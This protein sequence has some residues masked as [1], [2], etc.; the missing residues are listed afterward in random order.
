MPDFF[1]LGGNS[2]A[3]LTAKEAGNFAPC[4]ENLSAVENLLHRY[5]INH[6]NSPSKT[7]LSFPWPMEVFLANNH[8]T[9]VTIREN[10]RRNLTPSCDGLIIKTKPAV[11]VC[12]PADC[13]AVAIR[14]EATGLVGMFHASRQT[15][16]TGVIDRF[17]KQW[18]IAGGRP[19]TTKLTILPSICGDC[20]ANGKDF[21]EKTVLPDLGKIVYEPKYFYRE[22][23]G[24][25]YLDLP[26]VIVNRL[27]QLGYYWI[28]RDDTCT[29]CDD[30]HWSA[31]RHDHDG[32]RSRNAAVAICY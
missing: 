1:D 20:F 31:R 23:A 15:I 3:F 26:R 2:F 17:L 7:P 11:I 16:L 29:F 18:R 30:K 10:A 4:R 24:L 32:M 21:F 27:N 9:N 14:D 8:T 6:P 19:Q 12:F 28:E 5:L 25:Y 22:I 13:A